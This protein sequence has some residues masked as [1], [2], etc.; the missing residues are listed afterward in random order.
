MIPRTVVVQWTVR[1]MAVILAAGAG[2]RIGGPKALL[3]IAGTTFLAHLARALA[4]PGVTGIVAVLG[5]QARRVVAEAGLPPDVATVVNPRPDE[6]MLGSVIA[7]VRAADARA[8]DAVLLHPVDH[9]LVAP[10]TVDGVLVALNAGAMVAVPAYGARRGH[11]GGFARPAWP[12]LLGA[13]AA[14][15]ARA[16]LADHPEWVVRVP[17]DGGCVAGIDTRE[18]YERFVGLLP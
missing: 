8:A 9:P 5:H 2:R 15:G 14:R 7:G 12:S 11:P 4:R 3:P 17:G 13:S 10:A 6:G 16:V 1:V 18:D